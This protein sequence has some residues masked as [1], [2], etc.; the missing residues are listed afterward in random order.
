MSTV[1]GTTIGYWDQYHVSNTYATKLR[2]PVCGRGFQIPE[3][4]VVVRPTGGL[5]HA[6]SEVKR[7]AE[8]QSHARAYW[9]SKFC[10]VADWLEEASA[11]RD[12]R[13][14]SDNL[15]RCFAKLRDSCA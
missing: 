2:A 8:R 1:I 7:T 15:R 3:T 11:H 12:S 14:V 9:V 4:S 5:A 10:S 6:T 13:I